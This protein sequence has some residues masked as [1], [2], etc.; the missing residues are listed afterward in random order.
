MKLCNDCKYSERDYLFLICQHPKNMK[1][2]HSTGKKVYR[3]EYCS[4]HR[5]NGW[6]TAWAIRQCGKPARWFEPKEVT[7]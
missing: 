2:D 5:L 1:I 3:W 7:A 6:V 4:T